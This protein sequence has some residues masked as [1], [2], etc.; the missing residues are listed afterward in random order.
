MDVLGSPAGVRGVDE[1]GAVEVVLAA[2]GLPHR[3]RPLVGWAH[4]ARAGRAGAAVGEAFSAAH[5]VHIAATAEEVAAAAAALGR[6]PTPPEPKDRTEGEWGSGR[7]LLELAEHAMA[8]IGSGPP[9]G[10]GRSG[11]APVTITLTPCGLRCTLDEQWA[12]AVGPAQAEAALAE[13]LA[14]ARR[15]LTAAVAERASAAAALHDLVGAMIKQ[16]HALPRRA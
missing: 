7:Q 11:A 1:L 6:A 5:R 8:R 14:A 3:I 12:A 2:D 9:V 13:A 16:L 4:A 15:D 10:G